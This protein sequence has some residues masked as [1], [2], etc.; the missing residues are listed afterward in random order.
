V[1]AGADGERG[2]HLVEAAHISFVEAS[3]VEAV[4]D[5]LVHAGQR[6]GALVPSGQHLDDGRVPAVE[7]PTAAQDCLEPAPPVRWELDLDD[8]AEEPI[9]HRRDEMVLAREVAVDGRRVGSQLG[10]DL[11]Q[12]H[13]GQTVTIGDG[14]RRPDDPFR[15]ESLRLRR[16]T[17]RSLSR[18]I[19]AILHEVNAVVN[20]V[21]IDVDGVR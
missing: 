20:T 13:T 19:P 12:R 1:D 11:S 17:H 18:G 6:W 21:D 4:D 3:R 8:A 9:G 16:A 2:K 7:V 15:V 10:A 14:E 5:L